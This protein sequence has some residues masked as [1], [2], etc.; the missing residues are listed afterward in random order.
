MA[1]KRR[2]RLVVESASTKSKPLVTDLG[3]PLEESRNELKD[4][5]V[6]VIIQSIRDAGSANIKT[7]A[8]IYRWINSSEYK[9]VCLY[10]NINPT[11]LKKGLLYLIEV[12]ENFPRATV[13]RSIS[14]LESELPN[15][16]L[17]DK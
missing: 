15:M 9:Q 7:R 8:E 11:T 14:I 12:S 3:K 16:K 4:L 10:A 2:F 5:W 6:K 1:S 17:K 13:V